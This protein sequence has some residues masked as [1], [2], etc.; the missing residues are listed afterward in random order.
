MHRD[1]SEIRQ[2]YQSPLG[3]LTARILSE[4][5]RSFWL[6]DAGKNI[7]LHRPDTCVI[8]VGYTIPYFDQ[9][10]D[11]HTIAVMGAMQGVVRWPSYGPSRV[12]LTEDHIL[13]FAD[14]S[15]EHIVMVHAVENADYLRELMDEV[16]RVL[17]PNGRVLM[18]VPNRSG[19]W[20]KSDNTPFGYGRPFSM[21]Q[22]RAMLFDAQFVIE[23]DRRALYFM[24]SHNRVLLWLAPV[25]EKLGVALMPRLGGVTLVEASKR[26]YNA[27]P[28]R[29][30]PSK[31][32]LKPSKPEWVTEPIPT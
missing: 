14:Q 15:V 22:I 4:K 2:F 30:A 29:V 21:K 13:P 24:P 7:V 8:G 6:D 5:I 11:C 20:A 18:V 32:R 3:R 12:V 1:V 16:W 25:L 17:K 9:W 23:H 10:Q 31:S 19:L 28:L 27:T 26:L